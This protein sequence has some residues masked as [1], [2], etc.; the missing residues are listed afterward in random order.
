MKIFIVANEQQEKELELINPAKKNSFVIQKQLPATDEYKDYDAFFILKDFSALSNFDI[1]ENKPVIIN[2]VT[3]TL[4]DLKLPDNFHRINAWPGFLQRRIWEVASNAPEKIKR[5]FDAFEKKPFFVK[6]EPG[7]VSAR[8][9]SMIINEAFFALE[10]KISTKDE[11]DLAM[12]TG[13]NY[14]YGPFEWAERIGVGNILKLLQ[15]LSEKEER[16]LPAP[17]LESYS[18]QQNKND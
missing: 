14:P 5:L 7:F 15:K 12:K 18:D 16:Y 2:E 3:E 9:I 10:E 6:D 13:T 8:V 4:T 11:I 1:F 17:G